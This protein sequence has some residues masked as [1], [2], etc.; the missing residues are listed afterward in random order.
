MALF[1]QRKGIRPLQKAIQ[2]ESM[3]DDLR[4]RL[5]SAL[6]MALWDKWTAPFQY[7]YQDPESKE[8]EFL[9]EMAWLHFFKLPLDTQPAY[10]SGHP[11]S[12]Y[13]VLRQHFFEGEWWE[14]YDFIEF[15]LKTINPE[16]R[17]G[18]KE[19]LNVFL[20]AEDAAYRIVDDEVV[21]ITD[22]HEIAAVESAI[23]T[24]VSAT[25]RHLSKALE[26][27]SDRKKPDYR[28]S[29]SK[30]G[31]SA[32]RCRI[33]LTPDRWLERLGGWRAPCGLNTLGRC[34]T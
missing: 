1:S 25:S 15:V 7:G 30:R 14:V 20:E 12:G 28:N 18:L 24:A 27:L 9:L 31:Q 4:N 16:W 13:D 6:K 3:D 32:H 8:V 5:W 26:M 29:K 2:R 34:I 22:T 23:S 33:T 10:H 11:K 17:H 21:E 19:I